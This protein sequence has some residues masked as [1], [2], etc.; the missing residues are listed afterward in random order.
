MYHIRN[1]DALVHPGQFSAGVLGNSIKFLNYLRWKLEVFIQYLVIKYLAK[2]ALLPKDQVSSVTER[3]R[4]DVKAEA[5]EK[6]ATSPSF[7]GIT[8]LSSERLNR[9]QEGSNI[10]N[11]IE[12]A[13]HD[14]DILPSGYRPEPADQMI[15]RY[16]DPRTSRYA[17]GRRRTLV[18]DSDNFEPVV[19]VDNG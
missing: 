4:L 19:E 15:A 16:M 18:A 14:K 1:Y 11:V 9:Y 5:L 2:N 7:V 13:I 10:S 6:E 3:F 17:R 8:S 12:A